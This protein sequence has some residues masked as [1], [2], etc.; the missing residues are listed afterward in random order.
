MFLISIYHTQAAYPETS[1][2]CYS[3]QTKP[4]KKLICPD[5]RYVA[6]VTVI[7]ETKAHNH[8]TR[9]YNFILEIIF[10]SKKFPV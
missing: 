2:Q 1:L 8:E 9:V 5:G 6:L 4:D 10:V 3:S 7:H